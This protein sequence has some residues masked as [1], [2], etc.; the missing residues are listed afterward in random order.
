MSLPELVRVG[1]LGRTRGTNGELWITPDTDFPDRF[2]GLTEIYVDSSGNW[3][4]IEIESVRMV[5]G[6]PVIK[7]PGIQTPEEAALMTNKLLAVSK[8]DVVELPDGDYYI[9][10]LIGCNAFDSTTDDCIGT[11]VDVE[12][13]PAND[14]YVVESEDKKKLR[15]PAV[16]R[17]VK[18]VN[19]ERQRIV[20]DMKQ[21]DE[22]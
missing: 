16:V 1:Q 4:K 7:F 6:R 9:F 11:V 3:E 10:D 14:V 21:L 20:V 5:S 17:F 19:I 18:D 15:I 12:T 8:D 2:I 22:V 13:Y